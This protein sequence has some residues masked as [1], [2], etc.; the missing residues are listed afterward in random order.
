MDDGS[1]WDDAQTSNSYRNDTLDYVQACLGI[2]NDPYFNPPKSGNATVQAFE[3]LVV[4]IV[5][6]K[7][8]NQII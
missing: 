5:T 2:R 1:L 6:H 7:W 8:T 3:T 4:S